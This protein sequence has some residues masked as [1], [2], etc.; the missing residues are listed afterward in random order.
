MTICVDAGLS[1]D[2]TLTVEMPPE[3]D[4]PRWVHVLQSEIQAVGRQVEITT[5]LEFRGP[6]MGQHEITCKI[7]KKIKDSYY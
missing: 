4:T 6:V 2:K 7:Y 1:A 5:I 3:E